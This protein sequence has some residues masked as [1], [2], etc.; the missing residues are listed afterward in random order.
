MLAGV[1]QVG[2]VEGGGGWPLV[3]L[4]IMVVSLSTYMGFLAWNNSKRIRRELDPV[5]KERLAE[6]LLSLVGSGE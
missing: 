6:P 4:T 5:T 2:S 3:F 1:N